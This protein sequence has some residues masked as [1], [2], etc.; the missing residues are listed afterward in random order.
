MFTKVACP[1]CG[2]VFSVPEGQM[3]RRLSC[4]NCQCLFVA[5]KTAA[6]DSPAP[7]PVAAVRATPAP[8]SVNKTVLGDI[9]PPVRYSCPR[10]KTSLESPASESGTKKPCPSCGQRLQVPAPPPAHAPTPAV[11]KTVLGVS[12]HGGPAVVHDFG[13]DLIVPELVPNAPPSPPPA[14]R[15]RCLECGRDLTGWMES[16]TCSDCGSR[17]CS[18]VCMREHRYQSHDRRPRRQPAPEPDNTVAI[19]LLAV[20]LPLGIIALLFFVFCIGL[21]SMR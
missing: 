16:I 9:E 14:P 13:T 7:T 6:D 21:G 18:A 15:V 19:V 11:N 10:C 4:P 5:G 20:F 17:L 1:T 2:H 3:G 8:A 12:E